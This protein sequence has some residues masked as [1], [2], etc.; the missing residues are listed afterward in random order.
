MRAGGPGGGPTLKTSGRCPRTAATPAAAGHTAQARADSNGPR[1]GPSSTAK[2]SWSTP[3]STCAGR[4]WSPAS[5]GRASRR[6]PTPWPTSW[7]SARCSTGR[8]PARSTLQEGLYRYDAIGRAPGGPGP[9]RGPAVRRHRPTTSSSGRWA[10]PSC[11]RSGPR[12]L[13]IDEIDKSDID[14]PNDL[15]NIFEEGE[16]EIPELSRLP[17]LAPVRISTYYARRRTNEADAPAAAAAGADRDLSWWEVVGGLVRCREF[18]FVVMT[19]NGEREFPAPFHRRC[20]RLELPQPGPAKLAEIVAAHFEDETL[21][22]KDS[23]RAQA[24]RDRRQKLIESFLKRPDRNDLATDQLLNAIYLLTRAR[25]RTATPSHR[26]SMRC[27]GRWCGAVRHDGRSARTSARGTPRCRTRPDRQRGRRR[28]LAGGSLR[29]GARRRGLGS[30]RRPRRARP[31]HR[32]LRLPHRLRSRSCRRSGP[33]RPRSRPGADVPGVDVHRAGDLGLAPQPGAGPGAP[34]PD[35]QVASRTRFMLDE[36]ETVERIAEA[37]AWDPVLRPTPERRFDLM[38]V[39]EKSES[40]AVWRPTVAQW[41]RLLERQGAFRDVRAWA[42][43]PAPPG[44]GVRLA[45]GRSERRP[46]VG[47]GRVRWRCRA[48]SDWSSSSPTACPTPGTPCPV[49]CPLRMGGSPP[50]GG[51]PGASPPA[52]AG[53]AAEPAGGGRGAPGLGRAEPPAGRRVATA[54]PGTPARGAGRRAGAAPAAAVGEA[55]RHPR[56]RPAPGSSSPRRP[57]PCA[58]G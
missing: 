13:L 37:E 4:C 32:L 14:L 20:L 51:S 55:G 43:H 11:R 54:P 44:K 23:E 28:G 27:C 53:Y 22:I 30:S 12:V 49:R 50:D 35:A 25:A 46:T 58:W 15:L 34:P 24:V 40:M 38:L 29:P 42:L 9:G 17:D 39:V 7:S 1:T 52:L 45:L 41:R 57:L 31:L 18:P 21:A 19:N 36:E 47:S 16:F 5:P 6:S 8:S 48:P 3:R 2:S 33:R 10:P 26:S 56:G